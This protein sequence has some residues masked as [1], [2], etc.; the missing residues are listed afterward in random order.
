MSLIRQ[1]DTSQTSHRSGVGSMSAK[2]D[3][4]LGVTLSADIEHRPDRAQPYRAR[5]RWIEP[6]TRKRR[7]KSEAFSTESAAQGWIETLQRLAADGV[8]PVTATM[9]LN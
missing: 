2:A 5:V 7:S 4:P 6:T 1:P 3:L 9:T 8:T